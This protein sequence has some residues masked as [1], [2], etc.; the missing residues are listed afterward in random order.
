MITLAAVGDVNP[1]REDPDSLFEY[2][3]P[4]LRQADIAFGQLETVFSTRGVPQLAMLGGMRG[5]PKNAPSVA[6][7]GFSVMSVAGNHTM[8]WGEEAFFDTLNTMRNLNVETVGV[9]KDI[10]EA[11]RPAILE[12]DGTKVA[13]L[14]YCSVLPKGY[15][16]RE[17]KCGL[18]P[19]RATTSYQQVDWQAGTPP[20]VLTKAEPEDLEALV[21]D[22]N[23][24]KAQA[25]VVVVSIHWGIHYIPG[26]LAMYEFEV[27]HAAID[28]GA[29]LILGHHSHNIKGIEVYKGMVI[30]H[31]IGNFAVDSFI[32]RHNRW[33]SIYHFEPDPEYPTYSFP[34]DC[35]KTMI[36]KCLIG[37]KIE[38][39]SYLPFEVNKKGQPE[40]LSPEDPRS[41]EH[42]KYVEWVCRDQDWIQSSRAKAMRLSSLPSRPSYCDY[43]EVTQC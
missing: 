33:R 40:P 29:N 13:F 10:E 2:A 31:S 8:D 20:L 23:K 7:A 24:A 18:A 41:E 35:R 5:D 12:R 26:A 43:C 3:G 16:A 39:V 11:R 6:R 25:D 27:G 37:N 28:A 38:K 9:G 32:K 14:G 36:V 42:F 17:G 19:M 22:V 4:V 1:R 34:P 15:D 21:D 30:F